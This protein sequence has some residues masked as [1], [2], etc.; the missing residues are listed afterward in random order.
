MG[1]VAMIEPVLRAFL[2]QQ[3][4]VKITVLSR[5]HFKP[6]FKNLKNVKFFIANVKSEH[7]GILGLYRL[8]K[9]L[10]LLH[11]DAIA[12]CHNVLRSKILRFFFSL[13]SVKISVIDKGRKE[14]KELTRRK[15]K[16][17]K[18]LKTTHERYADVFRQ[19]G[20]KVYLNDPV[21]PEK[22]T[23]DLTLIDLKLK[24]Q[25]N[26]IW[27]G[28]APFAKFQSKVYPLILIEKIIAYLSENNKI[29]I[30]LFG[31]GNNEIKILKEFEN[32]FQNTI[33]LAGKLNLNDELDC[34][35]NLDCMLSMDS[36]NAHLAAMLNVK[37][38]T[39][40]GVTHP[41][42]GFAPFNQPTD[43]AILPNLEQ[44]PEIPC[45]VYG[46][47][48]NKGYDRV[49]FSIEPKIIIDKIEAVTK[50]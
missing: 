13:S 40:W 14:K 5:Q 27:I 2:T 29:R 8:Y 39:L 45:S 24:F 46:K 41:Y 26:L 44:Y 31:G 35:A 6:I 1:D 21:F 28:I 47:K 20:F 10:K 42:A 30:F 11:I 50:I 18:Q 15:N 49:M 12:D 7:K 22:P 38:I 4:D 32:K 33:S 16:I 9:D 43:F 48:V 3:P 37:T 19:L 36:A 17:F 25:D 23:P 34:I